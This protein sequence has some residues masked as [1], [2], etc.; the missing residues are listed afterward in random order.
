MRAGAVGGFS[1]GVLLDALEHLGQGGL[2][3]GEEAFGPDAL[4]NSGDTRIV[5]CKPVIFGRNVDVTEANLLGWELELG[6]AVGTLALLDQAFLMQ[7]QEAAA[8]HYCALSERFR[9]CR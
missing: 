2:V 1:G 8:N 3:H 9:N 4:K 6:S 5:E 7:E